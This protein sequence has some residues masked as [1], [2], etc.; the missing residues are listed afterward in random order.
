MG[1]YDWLLKIALEQ[2]DTERTIE[3]ARLLFVDSIREKQ[4]YYDILK[5]HVRQ[6]E[7]G[8]FVEELETL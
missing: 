7:W 1:W 4:P 6:E 8:S 5:A 2:K 3:Y